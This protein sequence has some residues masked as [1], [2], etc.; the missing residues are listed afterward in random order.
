M[1]RT[2]TDTRPV[3]REFSALLNKHVVGMDDGVH[4]ALDILGSAILLSGG[5]RRN[6]FM[7]GVQVASWGTSI[8]HCM[9]SDAL[10]L[11]STLNCL[12]TGACTF[13]LHLCSFDRTVRLFIGVLEDR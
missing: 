10:M 6:S 2:R 12:L 3:R 4:S 13:S 1:T 8:V 11:L 5:K 9:L 7:V